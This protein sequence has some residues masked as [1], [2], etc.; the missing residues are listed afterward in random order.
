MTDACGR[1]VGDLQ[2]YSMQ[3]HELAGEFSGLSVRE[4]E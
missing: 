1:Y 4:E 2:A 3:S